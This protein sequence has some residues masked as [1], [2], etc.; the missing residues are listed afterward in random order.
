KVLTTCNL[1]WAV[2]GITGIGVLLITADTIAQLL[3]SPELVSDAEDPSGTTDSD[4]PRDT[5][6]MLLTRVRHRHV[7]QLLIYAYLILL[8]W[9]VSS[10]LPD[11]E[12]EN[13]CLNDAKS[14]A[15]LIYISSIVAGG[16]W[17]GK[18]F[19][20]E[21]HQHQCRHISRVGS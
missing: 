16:D 15:M 9:W 1:L 14:I 18:F 12:S 10:C 2:G 17:T 6:D 20:E 4:I 3:T 11:S 21:L 7:I 5:H 19:G 8:Q 13:Q